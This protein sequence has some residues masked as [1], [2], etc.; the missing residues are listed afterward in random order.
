MARCHFLQTN[1]ILL[2]P[3][4]PRGP[5]LSGRLSCCNTVYEASLVCDPYHVSLI[6]PLLLYSLAQRVLVPEGLALDSS[7]GT[8]PVPIGY[9][10]QVE[11]T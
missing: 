2:P 1:F 8:I 7:F 4:L 3:K 9:Y 11:V 5:R 10:L 6:V